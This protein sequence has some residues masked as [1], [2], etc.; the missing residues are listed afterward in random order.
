MNH[1]EHK[2]KFNACSI[3]I[4]LNFAFGLRVPVKLTM[5]DPSKIWKTAVTNIMHDAVAHVCIHG[6]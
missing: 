4:L 1:L 3:I 6:N 2:F 5:G